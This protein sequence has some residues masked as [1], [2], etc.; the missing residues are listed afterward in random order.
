MSPM[1]TEQNASRM[2]AG[3]R[4]SE[5]VSAIPEVVPADGP[6][7]QTTRLGEFLRQTAL[8]TIGDVAKVLI[9]SPRTVYRL[10]ERGRIPQPVRLGSLLRWPRRVIDDWVTHG[11]PDCR[12]GI[13]RN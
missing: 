13:R 6:E 3:E 4:L 7:Q 12:T 8:L 11:C 2:T 5:V 10:A 1:L 9:C